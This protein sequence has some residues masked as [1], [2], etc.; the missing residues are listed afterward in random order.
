M[1]RWFDPR[2]WRKFRSLYGIGFNPA[3]CG[4]WEAT[5][6]PYS[7]NTGLESHQYQGEN[8]SPLSLLSD[9]HLPLKSGSEASSGLANSDPEWA[10]VLRD[11][12]DMYV[13]I[14]LGRIS[15]MEDQSV[16][17]W[18]YIYLPDIAYVVLLVII[19]QIENGVEFSWLKPVLLIF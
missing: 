19:R 8:T 16:E 10:V 11:K 13:F 5:D 2:W 4:M 6:L 18:T 15:V 7:G 3:S 14:Y 12:Y 9:F 17:C 1:L